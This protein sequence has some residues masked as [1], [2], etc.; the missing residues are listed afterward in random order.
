MAM[1]IDPD[2]RSKAAQAALLARYAPRTRVRRLRWSQGETQVLELGCGPPLL[3]VH[4]GLSSVSEW[5]PVLPALARGHRVIAVDRPG[6]G[7]ADAFDYRGVDLLAHAC[8]FLGDI[9]DALGIA[10]ADV[11]ANSVGGLW[12]VAYA[13]DQPE[14]VSKLV[15]AGKPAGCNRA[16]PMQLRLLGLPLVGQ[17]LGRRLMSNPTRDANRK[18]WQEVLVARP[19]M[20]DDTLLDADV[21]HQRRNLDT[22]IGLMKCLS[23]VR[24]VRHRLILGER[25]EQLRMPTAFL[26]GERDAFGPPEEGEAIA[27]RNPN[28]RV[29]RIPRAGH[30]PWIDQ[31]DRVVSEIILFL[32]A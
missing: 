30:L 27:A 5:V 2:L 12:A 19:E 11:V 6:H 24:G 28:L 10:S 20:L 7:L 3:L 16:V 26:W 32:A 15:L 31:P 29:I 8:R 21:A 14:R 9:M 4:G 1:N 18:F 17:W 23:D 22:M 13:L 25:W